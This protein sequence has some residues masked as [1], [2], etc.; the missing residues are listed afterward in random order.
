MLRI[1]SLGLRLFAGILTLL[2]LPFPCAPSPNDGAA[3]IAAGGIQLRSEPSISMEKERLTI[4]IKKVEV[5]YEFRNETATDITTEV[6]FPIPRYQCDTAG[7]DPHFRDFNVWVDEAKVDYQTI[8]HAL[9]GGQDKTKVLT[10]LKISD[11][12][13]E[14]DV[15]KCYEP[16]KNSEIGRLSSSAQKKLKQAGLIDEDGNP[17]WSVEKIYHWNMTFP[18]QKIVRVRHEYSP[19]VGQTQIPED[20]LRAI[21][22]NLQGKEGSADLGGHPREIVEQFAQLFRNACA[23]TSVVDGLDAKNQPMAVVHWVDY[24]LTTANTWKTP[25]KD[26]TLIVDVTNPWNK[27]PITANFCWDGPPRRLDPAHFIVEKKDFRPDKELAVY[28]LH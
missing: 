18:G 11:K 26:F 13:I 24:I 17:R 14:F 23:N 7:Q 10:D 22:Q 21:K 4:G 5:E 15:N 25:I 2:V 19:V 12:S 28:F 9:V 1:E 6:A 16:D 27:D 8:L 20:Y 3:S